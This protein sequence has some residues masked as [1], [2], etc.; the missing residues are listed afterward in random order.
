MWTKI[1]DVHVII[2][3]FYYF[4]IAAVIVFNYH[5]LKFSLFIPLEFLHW[6][7]LSYVTCSHLLSLSHYPTLIE[8]FGPWFTGLFITPASAIIIKG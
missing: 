3:L 4:Q 8:H 5:P 1:N 6:P 7:R 2:L